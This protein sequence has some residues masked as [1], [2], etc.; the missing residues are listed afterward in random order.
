[1]KKLAYILGG[2]LVGLIVLLVVAV[3]AAPLINWNHFKPQIADAVRG[4]TG[5]DLRIGGDLRISLVPK[6][7]VSAGDIHLSNAAGMSAPD[8]VSVGSVDLEAELLPLL[9]KRLV[10]DSLIVQ[11]PSVNLEV[12]KAGNRNWILTAPGAAPPEAAAPQPSGGSAASPS[13]QL[14][15]IRIEQGH[16]AYLDASTG[17][18][19]EAKSIDVTMAMA[20]L[21]KPLSV[22]GR[23]ILNDEPVATDVTVDSL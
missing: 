10:I 20:D 18:A 7:R 5:R 9:G 4:A 16:L 19:V 3:L 6:V 12:D 1:M 21:A 17:Q 14:G 22:K 11:N 2:A 15:D 8:M 23:M 13:V